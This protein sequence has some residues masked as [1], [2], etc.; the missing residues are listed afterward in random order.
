M[1]DT[2]KHPTHYTSHPSGIEAITVTQ[3]MSFCLGNVMKYIWRAGQKGDAVEDLKKARQ[4][5]D[6]EIERLSNMPESKQ[7]DVL[8]PIKMNGQTPETPQSGLS[9]QA[10]GRVHA[11]VFPLHAHP[12]DEELSSLPFDYAP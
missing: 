11:G 7:P 10:P 12:T 5:L 3:H 9:D 6:Y 1:T 2:I 8:E 4:Y